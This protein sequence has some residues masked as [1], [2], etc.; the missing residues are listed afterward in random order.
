MITNM[1]ATIQIPLSPVLILLNTS[2]KKGILTANK[3]YVLRI[4]HI[5][6]RLAGVVRVCLN[7]LNM[8]FH[9]V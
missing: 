9:I 6:V 1:L 7:F 2:E 3:V 4:K 8:P 5:R